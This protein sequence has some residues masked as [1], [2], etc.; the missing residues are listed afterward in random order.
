MH[1]ELMKLVWIIT[2]IATITV[3][4]CTVYAHK[5]DCTYTSA[6]TSHPA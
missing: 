3:T 1:K 6:R 5:D 4:K 2:N